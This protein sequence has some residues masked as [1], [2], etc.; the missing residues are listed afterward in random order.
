MILTIGRN[1]SPEPA[2]LGFFSLRGTVGAA[3]AASR[4]G[5][6]DRGVVCLAAAVVD[7]T[8][9]VADADDGTLLVVNDVSLH[10]I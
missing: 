9:A 6:P 10:L 4:V 8:L 3:A 7:T 5:N 1:S 2:L